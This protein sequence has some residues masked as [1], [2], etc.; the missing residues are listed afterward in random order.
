[1][2]IGFIGCGYMGGAMLKGILDSG[3][4]EASDI[5]ASAASEKT[6]AAK[7]NGRR[8]RSRLIIKTEG[9]S[10]KRL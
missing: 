3:K 10:N 8:M 2:K 1:M 6:I 5:I 4:C 7:H 9:Y